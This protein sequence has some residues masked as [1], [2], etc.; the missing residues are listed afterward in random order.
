MLIAELTYGRGLQNVMYDR[1]AHLSEM[2]I[3]RRLSYA[4][5]LHDSRRQMTRWHRER[6]PHPS[7]SQSGGPRY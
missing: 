6:Q 1:D 4:V 7:R 3:E 2:T 5:P